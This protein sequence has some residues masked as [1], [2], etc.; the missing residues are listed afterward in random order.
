LEI[1]RLERADVVL[2]FAVW[3]SQAWF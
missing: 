2:I 1:A 3:E